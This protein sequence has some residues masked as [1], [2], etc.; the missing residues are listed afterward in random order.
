M[1]IFLLL[2][3]AISFYSRDAVDIV[4]SSVLFKKINTQVTLDS[5][6]WGLLSL[7]KKD[8][9]SKQRQD[10]EKPKIS[11]LRKAKLKQRQAVGSTL[12]CCHPYL[13]IGE[14]KRLCC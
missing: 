8:S 10:E 11:S 7:V 2:L 3:G 1:L 6:S 13:T 5:G 4:S 12:S 14:F 9:G